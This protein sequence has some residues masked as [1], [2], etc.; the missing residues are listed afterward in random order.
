MR[1]TL[2]PVHATITLPVS[3]KSEQELTR[4][5]LI[6]GVPL[7]ALAAKPATIHVGTETNAWPVDPKNFD[8]LLT[9]LA[10]LKQLGFEGFET[11]FLNVR[12][13]FAHPDEAYEKLRKTGL[14]FFGVHVFLS[15]YD[16]QTAI[17]PTGLLQ[18]VA[19]GGKALGAERLIVS[20]GS[21]VH[22]LALQAKADALTKLAKY[23]KDVGLGCAY[24]NHDIEFR[25]GGAQIEGLVSK[26]DAQVH[27]ILDAGYAI[28][29]G[30]NVAEFFAKN[31]KRI[32]GI[33]LRDAKAGQE[34]PLGEGEYDFAPLAKEIKASAWRGWLLAEEER[35]NG[36]KPGESAVKP[37]R[38]AIRRVFG[39]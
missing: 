12:S 39:V 38:E 17:A 1:L 9:V 30:G 6:L 37:A 27:F 36:D 14:R 4:R 22:P 35:L 13:Q 20:G 21:T 23:C 10:T 16:P 25:N 34:V 7:N 31:W 32:D 24:H 2:F 19:D 8:S 18:Q 29:G 28:A 26:T 11:G 15:T 33:H 5:A 3:L